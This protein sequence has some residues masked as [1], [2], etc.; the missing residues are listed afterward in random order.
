MNARDDEQMH[1]CE[2]FNFA[3]SL[4]A[5]KGHDGVFPWAPCVRVMSLSQVFFQDQGV[6]QTASG[7]RA[8][9]THRT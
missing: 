7:G 9:R 6:T 8:N 3:E 4:N 2:A 5:G 1:S